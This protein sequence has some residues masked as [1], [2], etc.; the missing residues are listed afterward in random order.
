MPVG[1][2][3]P[4]DAELVLRKHLGE[5]IGRGDLGGKFAVDR[6]PVQAR[7][8]DDAVTQS[9]LAGDLPADRDLIPGDHLD[10]YTEFLCRG[11]GFGRILARRIGQCQHAHQSP[12]ALPIGS[13]DPQ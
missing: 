11:Y 13:G 6:G 12:G 8:V 2:Q 4:D 10:L 9:N 1:L 3:Q 7:G 5:T